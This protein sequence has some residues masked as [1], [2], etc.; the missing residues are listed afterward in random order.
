MFR[1]LLVES[2]L[3]ICN[4]ISRILGGLGYGLD[5]AYDAAEAR[6]LANQHRYDLGLFGDRLSDGDGVQLFEEMRQLQ[7][8]MAGVLVTAV[9]NLYTVSKAIGAGMLRVLCKPLDFSELVALISCTA[10]AANDEHARVALE[11]GRAMPYTEETI[12]ELTPRDIQY[13]LSERDLVEIIRSVD[14]PFAG[15]ERL[16]F[17]DRDT[18]ERVVHLVRRWC[19]NRLQLTA[20]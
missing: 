6:T 1:I 2:D 16:E 14:Y 12:A 13:R 5:V 3:T 15:K 10:E 18:L 8:K 20:W 9:G 7:Q 11:R 17:F 19:R 4:T